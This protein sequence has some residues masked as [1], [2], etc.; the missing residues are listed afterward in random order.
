MVLLGALAAQAQNASNTVVMKVA[1][2]FTAG[3][4][5][6]AA[7]TYRVSQPGGMG[8]LKVEAVGGKESA[9]VPVITRLSQEKHSKGA[10][11]AALVFDKV[12]EQS[13]LS[14]VWMPGLDGFLVRGTTDE[15]KHVT[16]QGASEGK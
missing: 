7:G 4:T 14:E 15:H 8:M 13:F 6:L 9:T 1:F 16:L 2:P 11:K 10:Q 3:D 5:S 12:G